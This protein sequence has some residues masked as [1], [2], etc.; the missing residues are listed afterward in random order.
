MMGKR[1]RV[2]L[3][4]VVG[5]SVLITGCWDYIEVESLNFVMGAG[6]D[7]LTPEY[8]LTVESIQ[9]VGGGQGTEL[10][11]IV[12]TS[13]GSTFFQ[14]IRNLINPLGQRLFWAHALVFIVSE[15]VA[16]QGLL[17]AIE[18]AVRDADIRTS[19]WL[20]I[21]KDC[22]TQE[23]FKADPQLA[24]SVSRH[25]ANIIES[26]TRNPVF[27]AQRFWQVD[28]ALGQSGLSVSAPTVQIIEEEDKKIAILEGTAVFRSDKM[29]GWIDGMES[30]NFSILMGERVAGPIGIDADVLGQKGPVS[31]Q[32]KD[33]RTRIKPQVQNGDL[34]VDVEVRLQLELAELGG[35]R[36]DFTQP[37]IIHDLEEQ[38]SRS[39]EK[40]FVSLIRKLQVEFN[41]DPLGL[42]AAI[43]RSHP[44]VWREMAEE[45][46]E[47]YSM[48]PVSIRVIS[49]IVA[50]GVQ[51]KILTVRD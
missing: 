51:S 36:I 46:W 5:L 45:W 10:V 42:G 7:S 21:A 1:D 6:V 35:L 18:F 26:R 9:V 19:L 20:L 4:V 23:I 40:Q 34:R 12:S 14:A 15:E 17:P 22:S 48:V 24:D 38:V 25:L 47:V 31:F 29:V 3:I 11:P 41:S 37:S 8:S 16:R 13:K 33:S 39:M 49:R 30:R 27:F 43:K 32:V 50:T 44:Q 28:M 2:L